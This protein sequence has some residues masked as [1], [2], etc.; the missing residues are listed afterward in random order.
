MYYVTIADGKTLKA[1]G[2]G[3]VKIFIDNGKNKVEVRLE[4]VLWVPELDGNLVSFNKL[5][6]NGY[7][8]EFR[9]DKCFL[10]KDGQKMKIGK[11]DS[12]LYRICEDE[13]EKCWFTKTK[14]D[15]TYDKVEYCIHEW[16]RR[17]AHRNLKDIFLM[18]KNGLMI[19]DCDCEMCFKGKMTRNPFP[20]RATPTY[21]VMDCVVSDVCGA[22]PTESV[23]EKDILS[24]SLMFLVNIQN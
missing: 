11:F 5:V 6:R 23:G 15:I 20:K 13:E 8:V 12:K 18:K 10:L 3:N 17:M 2:R 24:H 21:E 14:H 4:D 9:D 16:H 19:K 22:M 1:N 7:I